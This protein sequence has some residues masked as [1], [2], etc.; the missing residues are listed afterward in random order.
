M[1]AA[2]LWHPGHGSGRPCLL[3]RFIRFLG[4]FFLGDFAWSANG[5]VDITVVRAPLAPGVGVLTVATLTCVITSSPGGT[6]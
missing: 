3:S 5:G 1:S 2:S 4:A 6:T